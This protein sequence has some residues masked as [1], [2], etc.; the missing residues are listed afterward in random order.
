MTKH[1]E[2]MRSQSM[3]QIAGR[4]QAREVP[5]AGITSYLGASIPADGMCGPSLTNSFVFGVELLTSINS[6][7]PRNSECPL[8][9]HWHCGCYASH[10]MLPPEQLMLGGLLAP[11]HTCQALC[12]SFQ[13][14]SSATALASC[15]LC[16]KHMPS[17]CMNVRQ[18]MAALR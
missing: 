2:L 14:R 6:C 17:N 8:R 3:T 5:Q 16:D 9:L 12:V 15:S 18:D 10:C 11:H 7:R 1:L 4:F 13:W